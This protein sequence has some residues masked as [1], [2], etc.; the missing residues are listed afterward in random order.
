MTASK[1]V[2][3]KAVLD[4][5]QAAAESRRLP[6]PR[7]RRA[8]LET[9]DPMLARKAGRALTALEPVAGELPAVRVAIMGTGTVGPFQPILRAVLASTGLVP[10]IET[11]P[12]GGFEMALA[13]GSL[14]SDTP[15]DVVVA[16]LDESFFVPSGWTPAEP[17]AFEEHV[18]GRLAVL[19]ELITATAARL[20]AAVVVHTIPLPSEIRDTF[21]SLRAR[22]AIGRLWHQLNAGLLDLAEESPQIV[23]I[24]LAGILADVPAVARDERLHRYGDLPYTDAALLALAQQ[25]RRVVQARVGA[26]RKVLAVDLDNTLWGGVLGEV[27]AQAVQLGGL[28]PGNC[29]LDLQRAISRLRDQGVILVLASK[30]DA[31]AV[32]EAL[33]AHPE[34]V[35]RPTAFSVSA[36]NWSSK[37]GNLRHAAE[38][39][40]LATDSFVFLDDS[41]FER[42]SVES[43]LPGV[44][45]VP[46]DG[47]PAYLVRSLLTAGWF[48]VMALTDTDRDRPELYRTQALRRTFSAGFGSSE[49]FLRALG[50]QVEVT[51]ATEFTVSRI[52]QLAARTNQFNLTGIRFDEAR[53]A[54]M[55]VG[56]AHMVASVA[57]TDRFGSEGLVGALWAER[58]GPVWR[59]LNLVLSCRVLGRG[60]ELAAAAWLERQ[61]LEAGA[62]TAE[63]RFTPTA[64][65]GAASDFWIR[66]GYEPACEAGVFVRDLRSGPGVVPSWI[67]LREGG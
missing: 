57:V 49:E 60:V 8:L 15:P 37:A 67:D 42:A 43:E 20:T 7:A 16:L 45:A 18:T 48:D 14:A 29:Y 11:G 36:V 4:E 51:R 10:V 62:T 46:A 5:V 23:A 38:A 19:R 65:N 28:Y 44:A 34:V 12:Y 54:A 1:P 55:S 24:D 53:T 31:A 66:A 25:V 22:A 13:T 6:G 30:N 47:D 56:P 64:R 63:G 50:M 33:I 27:G 2:I 41:E 17:K 3:D 21:I 32:E 26:S 9:S 39:L 35:L 59:V 61:A 58:D 52:A 40:S